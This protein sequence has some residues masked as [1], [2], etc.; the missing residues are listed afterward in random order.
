MSNALSKISTNPGGLT[1]PELPFSCFAFC[2]GPLSLSS[3]AGPSWSLQ[4]QRVISLESLQKIVESKSRSHIATPH[5]TEYNLQYVLNISILKGVFGHTITGVCLAG[6][7]TSSHI[8]VSLHRAGSSVSLV[9]AISPVLLRTPNSSLLFR[10]CHLSRTSF[11]K[12]TPLPQ[13]NTNQGASLGKRVTQSF[14]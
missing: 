11:P 1:V 2:D 9:S 10:K 14:L 12:L 13:D 8:L 7:D 6:Q 4:Q 3:M 5:I